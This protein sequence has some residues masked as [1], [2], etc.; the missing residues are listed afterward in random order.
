MSLKPSQS[1]ENLNYRIH[2]E[3]KLFFLTFRPCRSSL[4][5]ASESGD[6]LTTSGAAKLS[7]L[8]SPLAPQPSIKTLHVPTLGSSL[9]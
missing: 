8:Q 2:W 9:P 1:L 5:A 7:A 6:G 4:K 3:I